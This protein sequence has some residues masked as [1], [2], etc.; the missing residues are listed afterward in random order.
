MTAP[1]ERTVASGASVT[2][3]AAVDLV[4][5]FAVPTASWCSWGL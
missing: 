5:I 3:P 4:N 2:L 1:P